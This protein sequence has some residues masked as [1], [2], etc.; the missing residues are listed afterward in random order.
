MTV[1][2]LL[3]AVV[4]LSIVS[5]CADT[6]T[7]P[8]L[9]DSSLDAAADRNGMVPFKGVLTFASQLEESPGPSFDPLCANTAAGAPSGEIWLPVGTILGIAKATHLG[10]ST[11]VQNGC[12]E[13]SYFLVPGAPGPVKALGEATI[14]A[15]NGDQVFYSYD[16]VVE[17]ENF[18]AE[19]DVIITG[20]S[21]RFVG[22][23]GGFSTTSEGQS[24]VVPVVYQF[25]GKISSVGSHN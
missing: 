14:T 6:A 10:E 21:G 19:V 5:A 25:N 12:V 24:L 7:Q 8:Q 20:G 13:F 11:I 9:L 18:I 15:A 2:R 16:G 22:A 4:A 17:V 3:G 1:T 23:S